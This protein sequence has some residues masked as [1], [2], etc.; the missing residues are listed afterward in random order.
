MVGINRG[1][2]LCGYRVG[3]IMETRSFIL[4][5][6]PDTPLFP[7]RARTHLGC[8]GDTSLVGAGIPFVAR[9]SHPS[10]ANSPETC[11]GGRNPST[12]TSIQKSSMVEDACLEGTIHN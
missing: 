11:L 5:R 6:R 2:P 1:L 9:W 3:T 12:L 4:Q 8:V 7:V 10:R